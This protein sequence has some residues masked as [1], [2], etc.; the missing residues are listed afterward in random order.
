LKERDLRNDPKQ[1]G[2]VRYKKTSGKRNMWKNLEK[3]DSRNGVKIG[4][5]LLSARIKRKRR[6][7]RKKNT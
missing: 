1:E 4:G 3:I 2:F 7:D 6:K 5:F